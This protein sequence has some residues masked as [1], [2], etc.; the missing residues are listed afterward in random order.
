MYHAIRNQLGFEAN[1]KKSRRPN[2]CG[3]LTQSRI[4]FTMLPFQALSNHDFL[5]AN[6]AVLSNLAEVQT[7]REVSNIDALCVA[8]LSAVS[9]CLYNH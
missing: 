3:I 2:A 5:C 1:M 9:S 4:G 8:G 7:R 6:K